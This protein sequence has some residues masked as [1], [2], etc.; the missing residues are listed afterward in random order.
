MKKIFYFICFV[1][2]SCNVISCD[3][4]HHNVPNASEYSEEANDSNQISKDSVNKTSENNAEDQAK[5]VAE[6]QKF[7]DLQ[8]DL[9]ALKKYNDSIQ[10]ELSIIQSELTNIQTESQGKMGNNSAYAYMI[11]EF[12]I[13]LSIILFLLKKINNLE[14]WFQQRLQDIATKGAN[15]SGSSSAQAWQT[16][17]RERDIRELKKDLNTL[18]AHVDAIDRKISTKS[19]KEKSPVL[20]NKLDKDM[21]RSSESLIPQEPTTQTESAQASTSKVFYMPRTSEEK[22]FEDS[23]KKFAP[24]DSTYFKFTLKS[25]GKAEFE[26]D[27]NDSLRVRKSYDGRN[28]SITTVCEIMPGSVSD[29]KECHTVKHGEAELQGN[30]WIVRKKAQI[31]YR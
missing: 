1:A 2:L 5:A 19:S 7:M 6:E 26:F 28:D 29:P 21:E 22:R 27:C 23:Q 20:G 30:V 14:K 4:E 18:K 3:F 25:D 15:S 10:N 8:T 16:T 9:I 24:D 13:L 11:I 31:I 17:S 12:I